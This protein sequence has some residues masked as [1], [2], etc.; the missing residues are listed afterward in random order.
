MLSRRPSEAQL[1]QRESVYEA[2]LHA[3]QSYAGE[4]AGAWSGGGGGSSSSSRGGGRVGEAGHQALGGIGVWVSSQECLL[5]LLR[6]LLGEFN[7]RQ[8]TL[9]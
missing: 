4:A 8:S 1:Q 9:K 3:E 6:M 2:V 7:R 5:L